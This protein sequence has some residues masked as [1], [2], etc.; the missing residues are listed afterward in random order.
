MNRVSEALEL[1]PFLQLGVRSIELDYRESKRTDEFGNRFRW[2]AK[3]RDQYG[4]SVGRW[5]WDVILKRQP[6]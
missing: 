4:A 6:N 2:R 1:F 5:A 3:V